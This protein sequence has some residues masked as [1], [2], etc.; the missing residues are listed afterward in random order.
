MR[1]ISKIVYIRFIEKKKKRRMRILGTVFFL[2]LLAGKFATFEQMLLTEW[3]WRMPSLSARILY[4]SKFFGGK[5]FHL[6]QPLPWIEL[7]K[8]KTRNNNFVVLGFGAWIFALT[9]NELHLVCTC[10]KIFSVT[11]IIDFLV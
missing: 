10:A 7:T 9:Q 1:F 6:E 2:S 11:Y 4:F 5:V 3:N 8:K